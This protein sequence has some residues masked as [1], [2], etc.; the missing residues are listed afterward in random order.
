MS[1]GPA[2]ASTDGLFQ[3]SSTRRGWLPFALSL[4]FLAYRALS[5]HANGD[6]SV[7]VY[8]DFD[9]FLRPTSPHFVT[10]ASQAYALDS[11]PIE[12]ADINENV[13]NWNKAFQVKTGESSA[14]ETFRQGVVPIM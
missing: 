11:N 14:L 5:V 13:F 8:H 9:V 10:A 6:S 1:S 2:S 7:H 3:L 4:F 12:D